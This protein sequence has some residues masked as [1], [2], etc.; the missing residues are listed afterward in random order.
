MGFGKNIPHILSACVHTEIGHV[1]KNFHLL[2]FQFN[3]VVT[4]LSVRDNFLNT[5]T[6]SLKTKKTRKK[7]ES[8]SNMYLHYRVKTCF[9]FRIF[10]EKQNRLRNWA[11][12]K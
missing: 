12:R 10:L 8:K 3:L 5:S 6:G 11:T 1:A 2:A 7:K 4:R 9:S